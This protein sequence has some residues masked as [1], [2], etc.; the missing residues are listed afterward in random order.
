MKLPA[1][2]PRS[3]RAQ[4]FFKTPPGSLCDDPARL[5][6]TRIE[7]LALTLALFLLAL[8]SLPL[9]ANTPRINLGLRERSNRLV[10]LANL[11][12]IGQAFQ[13]W[14]SD[15]GDQNPSFVRTNAGGIYGV[16]LANNCWY[17]FAWVSNE[18][19]TPRVLVCPSDTNTTRVARD[20]SSSP[21]GGFLNAGYRNNALSY[22][23][24]L[25]SFFYS[26]S[27]LSGDRNIQPTLSGQSCNYSGLSAVL[28][29]ERRPVPIAEW[30]NEVHGSTGNLLFN[31][32]S[33]QES[34]VADLRNA[35]LPEG[36]TSSLHILLPR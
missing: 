8:V 24:S 17:H 10:C 3:L 25:H 26:P 12:Q 2:S 7:L 16:P 29:L 31:D 9:I 11:R 22:L 21:D 20:F 15:H 28:N 34:S 32:G 27:I 23:L 36:G 13:L 33:A 18:L 14:A 6:F 30:N 35:L 5:A 1:T 4:T 19:A